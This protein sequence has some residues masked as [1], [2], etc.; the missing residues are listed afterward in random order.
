M[1]VRGACSLVVVCHRASAPSAF[2]V[3]ASGDGVNFKG[4]ATWRTPAGDSAAGVET[5]M[6]EAAASVTAISIVMQV[7]SVAQFVGIAE[8]APL[9]EPTAFLLAGAAVEP[10]TGLC[11]VVRESSVAAGSCLAAIA[12]GDGREVYEF[13]EGQRIQ[14]AANGKCLVAAEGHAG[15]GGRVALED[16]HEAFDVGDGRFA[17]GPVAGGLRHANGQCLGMVAGVANLVDCSA[18]AEHTLGGDAVALVAV[19]DFDATVVSSARDAATLLAAGLARQ[20]RL[21]AMLHRAVPASGGCKLEAAALN[22]THAL[23]ASSAIGRKTST[24]AADAHGAAALA[25]ANIC[26]ALGVDMQ[27]VHAAIAGSEHALGAFHGGS[28][29][30]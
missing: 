30:K 8:V 6:F 27:Q 13:G 28:V 3:L 10:G 2:K 20:E 12:A 19:P 26:G 23:T 22:G 11:L 5:V 17:W 15:G 7:S 25:V 29:H 18:D 14:S 9:V 4:V 24:G 16:C 21:L 1:D